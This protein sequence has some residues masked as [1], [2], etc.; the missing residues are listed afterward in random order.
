M[1]TSCASGN[2]W[3]GCAQN[4][5][6]AS[7]FFSCDTIPGEGDTRSNIDSVIEWSKT[8]RGGMQYSMEAMME[9]PACSSLYGLCE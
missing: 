5:G 1:W 9:P 7:T 3:S 6:G 8:G 2:A 4:G